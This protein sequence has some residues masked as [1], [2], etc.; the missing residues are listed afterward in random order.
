[1]ADYNLPNRHE[2]G[3]TRTSGT[4]FDWLVSQSF[5]ASRRGTNNVQKVTSSWF[6]FD[7][8]IMKP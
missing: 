8:V 3:V 7:K 4:F 6:L 1:M 5:A 2:L